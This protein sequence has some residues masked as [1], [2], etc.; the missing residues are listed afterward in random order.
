M[1][2]LDSR[3]PSY[4]D[5]RPLKPARSESFPVYGDLAARLVATARHP[6]DTVAHVLATCSGYAYSQA[7]TVAMIMARMGLEDNRCRMIAQDVNAML[8]SSTSFLVQSADGR[9]VI[10]AYRGTEPLNFIAW[11][12]DIDLYPETV[13]IPFPGGAGPFA[14]HGGFYRNTRATRYEI[15]AALTRAL[16]G[17]SV[18]GDGAPMPNPLEALYITG[19]SLG[20]AMAALM[21]I[22][23][24]T[25]PAYAPI[26]AKLRAVYTFGQPMIGG[27]D[28]ARVCADHDFLA[29]KLIRYV[30][31][32]DIVPHL[33][34]DDSGDFAHFG[35]EFRYD[36]WPW[37]DAGPSEQVG[38][39]LELLEA[40][41]AFV[42]RQLP[43]LRN[44]PFQYSIDDH[45]PHHYVSALTPPGA[46]TE[47]G[48][49]DIVGR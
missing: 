4:A 31:K 27:P 45:G 9:V 17:E 14:V 7:D 40:P 35:R 13:A 48:G 47:F 16:E 24:V 5:L 8:I 38:S 3:A 25:D 37:E 46:P 43:A 1:R 34:P 39:L 19:H 44:L 11:L 49:H 12:T 41:L 33:P 29:H 21:A 18:S 36:Q 22:M 42:A 23:L 30:Y 20:G 28:F 26:A 10:L 32:H 6:D 2:I 15:V